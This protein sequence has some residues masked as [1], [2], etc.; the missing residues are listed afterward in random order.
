MPP[1]KQPPPPPSL[2]VSSRISLGRIAAKCGKGVRGGTNAARCSGRV[3][4]RNVRS[5]S[6]LYYLLSSLCSRGRLLPLASPRGILS[7]R[8]PTGRPLS[9]ARPTPFF[10]PPS[11]LGPRASASWGGPPDRPSALPATEEGGGRG[12]R[13]KTS[14]ARRGRNIDEE[15]SA[16]T[17]T[18]TTQ[19]REPRQAPQAP[20]RRKHPVKARRF[21]FF[22][23][24]ICERDEGHTH[25]DTMTLRYLASL[26]SPSASRRRTI[27]PSGVSVTWKCAFSTSTI[28]SSP[29]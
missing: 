12:L 18:H 21:F 22:F 16:H 9:S 23:F 1:Q 25:T 29:P 19:T 20:A 17:H 27:L 11:A 10:F 28:F 3:A 4:A 7:G 24:G 15:A 13:S 14:E 6:N 2:R 8:P 5:S 26:L